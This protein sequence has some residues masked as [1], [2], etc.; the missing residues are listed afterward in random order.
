MYA[1]R[2]IVL[3]IYAEQSARNFSWPSSVVLV[4]IIDVTIIVLNYFWW[5]PRLM[6]FSSTQWSNQRVL[7]ARLS[8]LLAFLPFLK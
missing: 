5:Q 1:T 8:A 7:W 2:H 3:L 6:G 4:L